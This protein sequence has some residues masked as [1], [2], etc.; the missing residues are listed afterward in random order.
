V[1]KKNA[2]AV[3][4]TTGEGENRFNELGRTDPMNTVS[5]TT[6]TRQGADALIA[7]WAAEWAI[8]RAARTAAIRRDPRFEE[9]AAAEIARGPWDMDDCVSKAVQHLE[10]GAEL[11]EFPRPAMPDWA[12]TAEAE[13]SLMDGL[14][15]VFLYGPDH[16]AGEMRA[17]V[18]WGLYVVVDADNADGEPVGTAH[19][20]D[21]DPEVVL[22]GIG[23]GMTIEDAADAARVLSA[24]AE[25]RRERV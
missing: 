8:A 11:P 7:A 21:S 15:T 10:G 23:E 13:W 14:T 9:W 17:R 25:D 5:Q 1:S 12:V 20:F 18:G 6:D 24:V 22:E 16:R 3:A 19:W 2:P 4:G